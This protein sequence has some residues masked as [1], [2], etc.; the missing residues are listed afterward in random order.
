MKSAEQ[1]KK[2]LAPIF[3][4]EPIERAILIGSYANG[5]NTD[6]SDVDIVIDSNGKLIGLDFFRILDAI[7]M[8]LNT[9]VDMFEIS[10]VIPDS[11]MENVIKHE[12]VILYERQVA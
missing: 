12:G 3:A 5:T 6:L 1:I 8:A 10:E 4:N 7:V 9:D 11:P 2:I